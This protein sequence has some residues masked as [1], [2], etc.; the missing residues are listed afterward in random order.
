VTPSTKTLDELQTGICTELF[1]GSEECEDEIAPEEFRLTYCPT[2]DPLDA[3]SEVDFSLSLHTSNVFITYGV[4]TD[5]ER[6]Q[7][8]E[9]E[10][11]KLNTRLGAL[12]NSDGR[13]S[14]NIHVDFGFGGPH[15]E[16]G[17]EDMDKSL[18]STASSD[19][20]SELSTDAETDRR[21]GLLKFGRL[22]GSMP[23]E[24]MSLGPLLS[25]DSA[26]DGELSSG[27]G[28]STKVSI[29]TVVPGC[30]ALGQDDLPCVADLTDFPDTEG[31]SVTGSSS[32]VTKVVPCQRNVFT[33]KDFNYCMR[34]RGLE[35]RWSET[36]FVGNI[37]VL[38]TVTYNDDIRKNNA[39]TTNLTKNM[40]GEL[41]RHFSC[42][43]EQNVKSADC[44]ESSALPPVSELATSHLNVRELITEIINVKIKQPTEA[45]TTDTS[46]AEAR[47]AEEGTVEASIAEASTAESSTTEA[48]TTDAC[49]T[50]ACTTEAC[51]TEACTTEACTGAS[52]DS[53]VKMSNTGQVS[54]VEDLNPATVR[55]NPSETADDVSETFDAKVALSILKAMHTAS[56]ST[57]QPPTA[58]DAAVRV[59]NTASTPDDD[60]LRIM[61]LQSKTTSSVPDFADSKPKADHQNP[62]NTETNPLVSDQAIGDGQSKTTGQSKEL[63]HTPH[64]LLNSAD[65]EVASVSFN[66]DIDIDKDY[67]GNPAPQANATK[68]YSTSDPYP[69]HFKPI[70][71]PWTDQQDEDALA[72]SGDYDVSSD[73]KTVDS[74][75]SE[76]FREMEQ[77]LPNVPQSEAVEESDYSDANEDSMD[78]TPSYCSFKLQNMSEELYSHASAGSM[79]VDSEKKSDGDDIS[80]N[81]QGFISDPLAAP[82]DVRGEVSDTHS[83]DQVVTQLVDALD[84][85]EFDTA[86]CEELKYDQKDNGPKAST[87]WQKSVFV[88]WA[89]ANESETIDSYSADQYSSR[90]LED[91]SKAEDKLNGSESVIVEQLTAENRSPFNVFDFGRRISAFEPSTDT[92][93]CNLPHTEPS[94]VADE[95]NILSIE[96]EIDTDGCNVLPISSDKDESEPLC[97]LLVDENKSNGLKIIPLKVSDK[98]TADK[99]D[100]VD[101][102]AIQ[103]QADVFEPC[104]NV[105]NSIVPTIY[106]WGSS[107]NKQET[108]KVEMS[109][110]VIGAFKIS[111]DDVAENSQACTNNTPVGANE[112]EVEA[113]PAEEEP[114]S[115]AVPDNCELSHLLLSQNVEPIASLVLMPSDAGLDLDRQETVPF[116]ILGNLS[117]EN[118]YFVRNDAENDETDV[119][120]SVSNTVDELDVLKSGSLDVSKGLL[121]E[122]HDGSD[123]DEESP[124]SFPIEDN[125]CS[126]IYASRMMQIREEIPSDY[127]TA[128]RPDLFLENSDVVFDDEQSDYCF[129][130]GHNFADT[131]D[132]VHLGNRLDAISIH[133]PHVQLGLNWQI[134]STESILSKKNKKLIAEQ[135]VCDVDV[136]GNTEPYSLNH[137]VGDGFCSEETKKLDGAEKESNI[138]TESFSIP[139]ENVDEIEEA[140]LVQTVE[141]AA[142]E[143]NSANVAKRSGGD[144]TSLTTSA[145]C[146]ASP[147]APSRVDTETTTLEEFGGYKTVR[148][149]NVTRNYYNVDTGAAS[150]S[151]SSDENDFDSNVMD[152]R[153]RKPMDDLLTGPHFAIPHPS[154]ALESNG[155]MRGHSRYDKDSGE[156]IVIGDEDD[157]VK[158]SVDSSD[159]MN[160]ASLGVSGSDA[161]DEDP[162]VLY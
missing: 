28:G 99:N 117:D 21:L 150:R 12:I 66:I 73:L 115:G 48:C 162:D 43:I 159:G 97:D 63:S 9:S 87:E 126:Y 105:D 47:I 140:M 147:D 148:Q 8:S 77:L 11:E 144:R 34:F 111:D 82:G 70:I 124:S 52:V 151:D 32:G 27:T 35:T 101:S 26:S 95:S 139:G 135:T 57:D 51:T 98:L 56:E 134:V 46:T 3:G 20:I 81:D 69:Y 39:V 88:P 92:D 132:S 5:D 89:V 58:V 25:A 133:D 110:E 42:D 36:D 136:N 76:E 106:T 30:A 129:E 120:A 103:S 44:N 79:L 85:N 23:A 131:C 84:Q 60:D 31:L 116:R 123:E 75:F 61:Y 156:E 122:D 109:L 38:S 14:E 141:L 119:Y 33:E 145:G 18:R 50:E 161:S 112:S 2:V 49:T 158:E 54:S 74:N 86:Q 22:S 113:G 62:T 114:D 91:L 71:E 55:S 142:G 137:L 102:I 160:V 125:T 118:K 107:A 90:P 108:V 155:T 130:N 143:C 15:D 80:G 1:D 40:F 65:L 94:P 121:Y 104:A 154:D 64:S 4:E 67:R 68:T 59:Y 29:V 96:S 100:E 17:E 78:T 153:G 152:S 7:V 19:I 10:D 72:T 13:I 45:S 16:H 93:E 41:Y 6:S 127:P 157:S 37:R 128:C 24:F 83:G 149:F 53:I 138:L 146:T